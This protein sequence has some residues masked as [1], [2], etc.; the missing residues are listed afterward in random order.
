MKTHKI[1]KH[2]DTTITYIVVYEY[3]HKEEY[4]HKTERETGIPYTFILR[5]LN[6]SEKKRN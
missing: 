2:K 3:I 5:K 1:Y 6:A 4:A